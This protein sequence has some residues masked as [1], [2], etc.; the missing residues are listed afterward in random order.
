MSTFF[1]RID[2]N[3]ETLSKGLKKVAE[4]L[5][6][7]P[8]AFAANSAEKVGKAIDVSETMVIRLC[9]TLGY[10]GYSELQQEVR[11]H[12][13]EQKRIF[14]NYGSTN[15][16]EKEL[17]FHEQ[18]MKYDQINIEISAKNVSE[19]TY[20]QAINYL[21]YAD[22]VIVSGLRYTF[23]MAH[24]LTYA[25]N[26]I[27]IN[28]HLFRPD[29]DAHL[30]TG[31]EKHILIAFSFHAYSIETLL[32]AEEAKERG[33]IVIGITDSSIAPISEYADLLFTVHFADRSHSETAPIVFSMLNALVSG[34]S[35]QEPERTK[36]NK[37][38]TE[39]DRLKN[40]FKL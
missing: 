25:L 29:L 16:N 19:D 24:W 8:T 37:E 13:F 35:L 14:Q 39:K 26:S 32:L 40:I 17:P 20:R 28:A 33:W 36:Q 22:R 15:S 7:E 3:Y 6:K 34:V 18:V 2:Q 30:E 4:Y 10:S 1:E 9:R 21:S 31:S 27:G 23:S 11:E 5:L 12:V 38:I